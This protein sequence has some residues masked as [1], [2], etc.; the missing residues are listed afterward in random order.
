M[1]IADLNAS[2]VK[3]VSA[4]LKKSYPKLEVLPLQLD[5]TDES[6]IDNAVAQTASAF[7]RI[8]YAVNNAGIGGTSA[9]SG[10]LSV[11]DWRK[12]VDVNL[13]GVWM[14]SRAE[15]RQMLKQ[16]PLEPK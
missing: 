1:A 8:D 16:E 5:V 4:E 3:Q 12:V 14:S 2:A 7:G 13:N 9:L 6:A 15:I 11:A 10:D